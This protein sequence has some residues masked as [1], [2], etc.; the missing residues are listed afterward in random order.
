[1]FACDSLESSARMLSLAENGESGNDQEQ[2][3]IAGFSSVR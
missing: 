3:G 2:M 1:M